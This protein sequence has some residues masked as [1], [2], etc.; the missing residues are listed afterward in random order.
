MSLHHLKQLKSLSSS[1]RQDEKKSRYRQV[2]L[3]LWWSIACIAPSE[4]LSFFENLFSSKME[5]HVNLVCV[6]TNTTIGCFSESPKNYLVINLHNHFP[7]L[8]NSMVNNF[9]YENVKFYL[10]YFGITTFLTVSM[11]QTFCTSHDRQTEK[12]ID[13][14][15]RL[16][17]CWIICHLI[18]C[19]LF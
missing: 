12:N 10:V 8:F 15:R 11:M 2:Q 9:I 18:S 1:N 19:H 17:M 6:Y 13:F 16:L 14:I 7:V 5:I 4:Y 3:P